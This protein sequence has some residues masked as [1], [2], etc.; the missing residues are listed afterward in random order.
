ML[1]KAYQDRVIVD[2]KDI[3]KDAIEGN[4][5]KVLCGVAGWCG[6]VVWLGGVAGW[7]GWM[8]WLG[9]LAGW[10][11]WVVWLDGVVG[12]CGWMVWLGGVAGWC[13]WVLWLWGT[14]VGVFGGFFSKHFRGVF[15]IGIGEHFG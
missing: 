14:I 1:D 5:T 11:G 6:W 13:G 8:V 4:I 10:C 3:H 15:G 9:G 12:W 7:C 2:Y